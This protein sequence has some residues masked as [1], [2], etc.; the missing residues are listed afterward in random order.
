M[1][2]TKGAGTVDKDGV[3]WK[4]TSVGKLLMPQGDQDNAWAAISTA[5]KKYVG[6]PAVGYPELLPANRHNCLRNGVKN[7][8]MRCDGR[9]PVEVVMWG[10]PTAQSRAREIQRP[11]TT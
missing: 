6:S 10:Q 8:A 3:L 9:E 2:T 5:C 11:L 1:S 4:S 7:S